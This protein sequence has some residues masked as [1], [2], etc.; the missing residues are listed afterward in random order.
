MTSLIDELATATAFAVGPP[1]ALVS[2][3]AAVSVAGPHEQQWSV[4]PGHHEFA[5]LEQT[6]MEAVVVTDPHLHTVDDRSVAHRDQSVA[7]ICPGFSSST[8]LP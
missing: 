1:L 8:C 7:A 4:R 6:W 2:D 5:Q 3:A